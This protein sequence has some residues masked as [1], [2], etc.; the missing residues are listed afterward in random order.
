M[1]SLN[2]KYLVKFLNAWNK[3]QGQKLSDVTVE[4]LLKTKSNIK[5]HLI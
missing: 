5:E 3:L 1:D 2:D 4:E